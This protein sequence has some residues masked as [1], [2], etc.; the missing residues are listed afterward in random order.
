MRRK[1]ARG[2]FG[3]RRLGEHS[4]Y[5]DAFLGQQRFI[6]GEKSYDERDR[7]T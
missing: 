7:D 6:A 3:G 4:R 2:P 5:L 1:S